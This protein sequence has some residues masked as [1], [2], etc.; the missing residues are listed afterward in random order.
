MAIK[1]KLIQNASINKKNALKTKLVNKDEEKFKPI[2]IDENGKE[3]V[4]DTLIEMTGKDIS[5]RKPAD[6]EI[7]PQPKPKIK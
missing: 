7:P 2:I 6:A 1:I 5:F 4:D 3:I